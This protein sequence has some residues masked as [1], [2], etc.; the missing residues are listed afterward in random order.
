MH[1]EDDITRF[2][3]ALKEIRS[4][5]NVHTNSQAVNDCVKRL[6][7]AIDLL[8]SYRNQER[9]FS[10][11]QRSDSV[12]SFFKEK[13]KQSET[14]NCGERMHWVRRRLKNGKPGFCR[15]NPTRQGKT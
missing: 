7:Q 12:R 2:I 14:Y 8:E 9:Y 3:N 11:E 1:L 6:D 13:L 5:L 15:K 10:P 4:G